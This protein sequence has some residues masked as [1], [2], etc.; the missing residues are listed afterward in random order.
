MVDAEP[1]GVTEPAAPVENAVGATSEPPVAPPATGLEPPGG[2]TMPPAGP[3]RCTS[4]SVDGP[5]ELVVWHAFTFAARTV[6]EN[7]LT[8]LD[9]RDPLLSVR[10]EAA[11][12]HDEVVQRLRDAAPGSLPDLIVAP[13]SL[14]RALAESGTTVAPAECHDGV[15]PAQLGDLLPVVEATY[16]VDG[17]LPAA[18]YNV[19]TPLLLFEPERM[20][21]AGLDPDD[22]PATPDELRDALERQ[23]AAG[24]A[25]TGLAMYDAA[26]SWLIE[27]WAAQDGRVL[28][29]PANG[30]RGG[31]VDRFV[32]DTPENVAA[33]RWLQQLH[34]D[35]LVGWTGL[36]AS[37]FDNLLSLVGDEPAAMTLHTSASLGDVLDL[38]DAG[39]WGELEVGAASLPGPG[40]GGLVG[41]GA[42]WLIDGGDPAR[43]RAAWDVVAWLLEPPHLA[44][45]AGA[46]GY[47]PPRRSVVS[48]PELVAAWAA[49]PQ[50][51]AGY[52]QLAPLPGDEAR[53]GMQVGPRLAIQRL[54]EIAASLMITGE[55]DPS[56]ELRTAEERA[57]ELLAEYRGS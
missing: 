34:E 23:V 29:E 47:V 20:R 4:A 1:P 14:T 18:P 16:T 21:A 57:G 36:N 26:T 46:T 17:L 30:H 15:V 24:V 33:L 41:G 19:S 28:A 2:T 38:V 22:P 49:R 10:V 8:E 54:L 43:V 44:R 35:G 3:V 48:E 27:Q 51:R 6:F 55:V 31:E 53:A 56:D 37:G 50:L 13:V 42:L 5:H 52:D 32:F 40:T 12:G 11:P 7:L 39:T 45:L 9:E 25:S